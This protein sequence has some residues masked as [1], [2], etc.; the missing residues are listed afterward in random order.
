MPGPS[1]EAADR[2]A[3]PDRGTQGRPDDPDAA[4][5]PSSRGDVRDPTATVT[6]PG[7]TS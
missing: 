1:G 5:G 3:E 4:G 2:A 6:D 7:P